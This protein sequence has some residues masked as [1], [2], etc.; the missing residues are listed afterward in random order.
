MLAILCSEEVARWAAF[1]L[2]R[3]NLGE[4]ESPDGGRSGQGQEAL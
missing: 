4:S 2:L 3:A 1:T